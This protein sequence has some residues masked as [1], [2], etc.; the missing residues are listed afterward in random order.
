[1]PN[2]TMTRRYL[3]WTFV[4]NYTIGF[5]FLYLAKFTQ[6][7]QHSPNLAV[8]ILVFYMWVPALVSIVL[9]RHIHGERLADYGLRFRPNRGWIGAWVYPILIGFLSILVCLLLG[10]G[11]WDADFSGFIA[12]QAA[13]LNPEQLAQAKQQ[14][15][16]ISPATMALMTAVQGVVFGTTINALAAFGEEMGWRGLLYTQLRP[17]GF[18]K[19]NL[20]IGFIWGVWHAPIIAA[21]HNFPAHPIAGILVMTLGTVAMSPLIGY[22]RERSGSVIAAAIFH[23]VFNA[24]SGISLM[25][26]ADAPNILRGP[27]GLA[28]IIAMAVLIA[29]SYLWLGLGRRQV[30]TQ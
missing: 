8:W 28:G 18:W 13:R 25:L 19:A 14:L 9:I 17:M 22:V 15:A 5:V 7:F 3:A 30:S 29:V 21:G 4:I 2:R 11:R 26:I 6:T 24:A 10:I 12:E 20:L 27:L 16:S 1:M 23:G